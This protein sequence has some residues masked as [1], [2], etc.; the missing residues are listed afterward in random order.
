MQRVPPQCSAAAA[1]ALA[2]AWRVAARVE[3][4]H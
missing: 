3:V 1:G 2:E 4:T